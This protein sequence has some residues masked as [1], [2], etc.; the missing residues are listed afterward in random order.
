MQF[1]VYSAPWLR[2]VSDELGA[3][4]IVPAK[5]YP[6]CY[7]LVGISPSGYSQWDNF[8]DRQA[9]IQVPGNI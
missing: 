6:K 1:W 5:V 2:K 8:Q 9:D 3:R 4:T 7:H